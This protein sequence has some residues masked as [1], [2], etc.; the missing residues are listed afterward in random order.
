MVPK[1]PGPRDSY[2]LS[3][4]S[5]TTTDFGNSSRPASK[6]VN[7]TTLLEAVGAGRAGRYSDPVQQRRGCFS[8]LQSLQRRCR[9]L[10]ML[11]D[12]APSMHRGAE[13]RSYARA[14]F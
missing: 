14:I 9:M 11:G 7:S 13:R 4:Y 3:A 2:L 10:R 6:T 5:S 1:E 8:A 12:E